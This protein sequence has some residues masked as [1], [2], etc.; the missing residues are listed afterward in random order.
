MAAFLLLVT[1]RMVEQFV[2]NFLK[3]LIVEHMTFNKWNFELY[4]SLLDPNSE[5]WPVPARFDNHHSYVEYLKT[6]LDTRMA[7]LKTWL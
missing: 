7:W 5:V 6:W 3:I 4:P 1:T 2:F